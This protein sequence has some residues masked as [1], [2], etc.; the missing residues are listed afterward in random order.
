[1]VKYSLCNGEAQGVG[2]HYD[3][4]FLTLVMLFLFPH[5]KVSLHQLLQASPHK[6]LQAQNPL[7][8][9]VDIPPIEDTLVVNIGKGDGLE[10]LYMR[11]FLNS[12]EGLEMATQKEHC[13]CHKPP[14]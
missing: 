1:M 9:W 13:C 8:E 6:G 3:S 5:V 4:G 2:P 14:G 10:C 12:Y 7:G 11:I